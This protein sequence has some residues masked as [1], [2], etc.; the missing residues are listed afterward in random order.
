M[1]K[2]K[3]K[4]R[5]IKRDGKRERER[6]IEREREKGLRCS[7]QGMSHNILYKL[8]EEPIVSELYPNHVIV[9][10]PLLYVQIIKRSTNFL[11]HPVI[12]RNTC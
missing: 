3:K 9:I 1:R 11:G 4:G 10:V 8:G 12:K 2:R 5:E 6:E 7:T